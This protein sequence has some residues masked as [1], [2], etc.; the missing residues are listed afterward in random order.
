MFKDEIY[1]KEKTTATSFILICKNNAGEKLFQWINISLV[2]RYFRIFH[3]IRV[4]F[5]Y[6]I[7]SGH[8]VQFGK[9]PV[10]KL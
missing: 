3:I 4:R 7:C 5:T 8:V 1:K 9:F 2:F 10:Y 6:W